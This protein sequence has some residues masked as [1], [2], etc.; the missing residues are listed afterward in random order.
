MKKINE[1]IGA[2]SMEQDPADL[3]LNPDTKRA[4][5]MMFHQG[6]SGAIPTH[7]NNSPFLSGG[8]LTSAFGANPKADKKFRIMKYKD[9]IKAKEGKTNE[10]KAATSFNEFISLRS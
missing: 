7:W 8:R 9:F 5:A 4:S 1:A 3:V 2:N 6:S 10:S